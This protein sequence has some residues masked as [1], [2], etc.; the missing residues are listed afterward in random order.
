M[1]GEGY[2]TDAMDTH[3]KVG[4]RLSE[5]GLDAICCGSVNTVQR[6]L[7]QVRYHVPI[8]NLTALELA[9]IGGQRL[10]V[11]QRRL[12]ADNNFSTLSLT[13]EGRG[14]L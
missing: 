12:P 4:C 13:S 6:P 3:V 14:T 1:E 10:G 9:N 11:A 2:V 5:K 7:L 8:E